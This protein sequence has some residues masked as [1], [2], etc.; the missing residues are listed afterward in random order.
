MS[1]LLLTLLA[2]LS[3]LGSP[4]MRDLCLVACASASSHMAH[5]GDGSGASDHACHESDTSSSPAVGG[6]PHGCEHDSPEPPSTTAMA[7]VDSRCATHAAV[8][9]APA[10]DTGVSH[11]AIAPLPP[12]RDR[13]S[14]TPRPLPAPIPLRI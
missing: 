9:L 13:G 8:A 10:V 12:T 6:V 1:R 5:G 3:V 7:A 4:L 11:V 14:H 2:A